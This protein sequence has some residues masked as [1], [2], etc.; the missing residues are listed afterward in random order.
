MAYEVSHDC[1][2]H[3]AIQVEADWLRKPGSRIP[4]F[5]SSPAIVWLAV[6]PLKISGQHS[7]VVTGG[8]RV[9]MEGLQMAPVVPGEEQGNVCAGEQRND[10]L[11]AERGGQE[12]ISKVGPMGSAGHTCVFGPTVRGIG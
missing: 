8:V 7:R 1:I 9:Y 10:Y 2:S 12:S 3:T 4:S 6:G 11:S 5:T